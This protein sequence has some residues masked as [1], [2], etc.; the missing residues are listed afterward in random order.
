MEGSEELGPTCPKGTHTSS[1][2]LSLS[3]SRPCS[4]DELIIPAPPGGSNSGRH[5]G[6]HH[7]VL[8]PPTTCR[9]QVS[10]WHHSAG[11]GEGDLGGAQGGVGLQQK[12]P[13]SNSAPQQ[14]PDCSSLMPSFRRYRNHLPP[15]TPAD[16]D[17]GSLPRWPLAPACCPL[18]LRT[19]ALAA[20]PTG[21]LLSVSP[22]GPYRQ[23]DKCPP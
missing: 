14:P 2:P 19:L 1:Q 16:P 7:A 10:P 4:S 5:L 22:T 23:E 11:L 15:P 9:P 18:L 6:Q 12:Q 20:S 21:R 3:T 17:P 8:D 13:P